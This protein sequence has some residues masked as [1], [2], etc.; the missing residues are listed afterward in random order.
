[1]T[2]MLQKGLQATMC[3]LCAIAAWKSFEDLTGT[4]LI[5]RNVTGP[6]IHLAAIGA[7]LLLIAMF[8]TFIVLR[9]AAVG[10]LVAAILCL[11]LYVY[12]TVPRLFVRVS[13]GEWADPP[14]ARFVWHGWSI[15]GILNTIIVVYLCYRGFHHRLDRRTEQRLGTGPPLDA[16]G[17]RPI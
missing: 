9:V 17:G 6:I 12:R 10:A 5:G 8:T 14:Q 3:L 16:K 4:E 1:M 7:I 15:M 13:G 11:P 2:R